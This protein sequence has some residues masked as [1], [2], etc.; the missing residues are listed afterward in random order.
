MK[1]MTRRVDCCKVHS[2]ND[3]GTKF[4]TKKALQ[5]MS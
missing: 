2:V 1:K 3:P 4:K 5:N